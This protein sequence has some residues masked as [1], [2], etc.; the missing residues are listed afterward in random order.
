[1]MRLVGFPRDYLFALVLLLGGCQPNIGD[2]CT[3][4]TDCSATGNRLCEPNLPGGYCTI[5]NCEPHSC[6]DEAACVAYGVAPSVNRLCAVQQEQRLERTF[7]M[8]RCSGDGDCRAGYAC[9]DLSP[10][11][12]PTKPNQASL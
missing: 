4:H 5:F 6:P 12:D 10:P 8:R 11:A 7:C 3:Q 1:M 2:A 9:V